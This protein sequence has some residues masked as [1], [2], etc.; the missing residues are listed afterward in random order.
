M[1]SKLTKQL[2]VGLLL[3][4]S[5]VSHSCVAAGPFDEMSRKATHP[6]EIYTYGR[7]SM[8]DY[9][10]GA[11]TA[12]GT[13]YTGGV[14][15]GANLN[16]YINLNTEIGGGTLDVD[17]TFRNTRGS[18]SAGVFETKVNLDWN[19]FKTRLTPVITGGFGL[20]NLSARGYSAWAYT[21][22]GGGGLRWDFTDR[23]FAK[24]IYRTDGVTDTNGGGDT[25]LVH[26]FTGS[27]GFKF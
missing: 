6:G 9:N 19:I 11:L 18:G 15:L 23:F 17:G 16:D 13:G 21:Y 27:I 14:G 3:A 4:A 5:T 10:S 8:V 1:Q 20:L 25:L 12:N 7:I 26:G 24:A 22:G 2:G